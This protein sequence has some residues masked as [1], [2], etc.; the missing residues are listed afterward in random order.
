MANIYHL[1]CVKI[2]SPIN[3][4]VCGHCL[5]IEEKNKLILVDTGV[6]LLDTQ[7]PLERIGKKLID[8]VG[9]RFDE[10]QTAIRQIENLGFDPKKVTDCIISHL[11]NDHVGGLADF[12]DATIHVGI[13]E[14]ENFTSDNQRYLKTPLSHNPI[15]KTYKKNACDWFGFEA[16]RII[17]DI[18]TEIFLIPLFGHTLGHCGV[19]LKNHNKWLFYIADAYY[20]RVELTDN[21]HLVNELAKMRAD[22]NELRLSTLNKIRKLTKEHPEIEIFS[23]HDIKEF[24]IYKNRSKK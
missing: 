9:Y 8:M 18:E 20:M 19:A 10:S 11:D 13:E 2:V 15:I 17:A 5:L 21:N 14:F 4:N 3:A 1:N 12:P 24:K 16:R 7:K 22:D 6:G 23:Y